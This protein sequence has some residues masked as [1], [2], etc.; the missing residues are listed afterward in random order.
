MRFWANALGQKVDVKG[1]DFSGG[2]ASYDADNTGFILGADLLAQNGVRYGAAFGYQKSDLDSKGSLTSTKNKADA[3]S[4][5]GYVAKDF[6]QLNVIGSMGYTRVDADVTQSMGRTLDHGDHTLD[7]TNDVFTVGLKTEM[8]LPL[9]K[10]LAFIPYV[11][12]RAVTVL[13]SDETSK[14]G[15]KSAFNYS[16]DTQM[17]W[18]MPVG[19]TIQS[20]NETASGWKTRGLFDFSVTPVFGDK[21]ADTTVTAVGVKGV[22]SVTADYADSVTSAV[23]VGLSAEKDQWS[24]SGDMSYMVGDMLDSNVTFGVNTRYAF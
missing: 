4:L 3:F 24:F 9:T 6:G 5:T 8:H 13:S 20:V 2:S 7:A 19:L 14:M 22:D 21:S 11:G 17:Q 15:G 23:R 1:A 10:S 16:T 18:Q 12:L